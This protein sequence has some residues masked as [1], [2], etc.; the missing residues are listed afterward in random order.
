MMFACPTRVCIYVNYLI[1]EWG[2]RPINQPVVTTHRSPDRRDLPLMEKAE[3]R[4]LPPT[5]NPNPNS[6]RLHVSAAI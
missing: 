3:K 6:Q 1:D 5:P 4:P 2:Q